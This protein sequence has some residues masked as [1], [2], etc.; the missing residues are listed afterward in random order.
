MIFITSL[1]VIKRFPLKGQLHFSVIINK[2]ITFY[3]QKYTPL[4]NQCYGH[5]KK[6]VLNL[7]IPD[8]VF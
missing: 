8:S 2:Y 3:S 5:P 7:A 6:E 4:E 1:A